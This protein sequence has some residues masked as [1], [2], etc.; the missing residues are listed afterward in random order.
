[1]G[2]ALFVWTVNLQQPNQEALIQSAVVF[3]DVIDVLLEN[4]IST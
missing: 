1:L 3:I 4:K 2:S